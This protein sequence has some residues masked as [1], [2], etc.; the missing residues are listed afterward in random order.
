MAAAWVFQTALTSGDIAISKPQESAANSEISK[1]ACDCP[2][3]ISCSK[4]LRTGTY[5]T[6]GHDTCYMS[7][8]WIDGYRDECADGQM[9][10]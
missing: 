8:Q 1:T 4:L 3:R 2:N 7:E 6:L 9:L 10:E 5:F